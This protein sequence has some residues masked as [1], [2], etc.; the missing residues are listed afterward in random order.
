MT[1]T[2]ARDYSGHPN[3]VSRRA[4]I[5]MDMARD[6][7]MTR[8][9]AA[10]VFIILGVLVSLCISDNVGPRLLPLPST[11]ELPSAPGVFH[12][13]LAASRAPSQGRTEGARVEM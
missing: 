3:I 2:S 4:F 12:P 8:L 13:R 11:S 10:R 9:R 6:A 7:A 1:C 5:F